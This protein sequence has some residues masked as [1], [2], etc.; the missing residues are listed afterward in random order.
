MPDSKVDRLANVP[1]FARS[2]K[3]DLEFLASEVDEVSLPAGRTL[4]TEGQPTES[5]FILTK[6]SVQIIRQGKPVAKLG[7]GDFFGEVGMLSRGPAVATAVTDGPVDALVLSHAQ[8]RDAIKSKPELAMEV[9]A[10]MA[11]RLRA[12]AVA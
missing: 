6:G 11:E 10:A 9:I 7:P 5:F 3:R 8:F 4:I 1:L 2:S 12:I